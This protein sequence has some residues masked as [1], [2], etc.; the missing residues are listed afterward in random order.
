M[1][2]T[3]SSNLSSVTSLA[4][5]YSR[6][7]GQYINIA[8]G[9]GMSSMADP[10]VGYRKV[11]YEQAR[12]PPHP[13]VPTYLKASTQKPSLIQPQRQSISPHALPKPSLISPKTQTFSPI[14][15]S[16]PQNQWKGAPYS[17]PQQDFDP[18]QLKN[19]KLITP[20]E[21]I[22]QPGVSKTL[23]AGLLSA[24]LMSVPSSETF[25]KAQI[26]KEFN[27]MGPA[28]IAI[29]QEEG[30]GKIRAD[31]ISSSYSPAVQAVREKQFE[32]LKKSGIV[33][34]LAD[35]IYQKIKMKQDD[36]AMRLQIAKKMGNME[37]INQYQAEVDKYTTRIENRKSTLLAADKDPRTQAS[38]IVSISNPLVEKF[39]KEYGEGGTEI[40]KVEPVLNATE[41]YK[42]DL[43]TY[44]TELGTYNEKVRAFNLGGQGSDLQAV[45]ELNRQKA[46]LDKEQAALEIR[47][48]D[49]NIKIETIVA[50]VIKTMD[51]KKGIIDAYTA[52]YNTVLYGVA[53]PT[54][55]DIESYN[56][57]T[58]GVAIPTDAQRKTS[59]AEKELQTMV[60]NL[61]TTEQIAVN[62]FD[63]PRL[64]SAG[65]IAQ[66]EY[67]VNRATAYRADTGLGV[68]DPFVGAA[69]GLA[70]DFGAWGGPIPGALYEGYI[71][72]PVQ[73][74]YDKKI[75]SIDRKITDLSQKMNQVGAMYS[76]E[77]KPDVKPFT[78]SQI[79]QQR[80]DI[81]TEIQNLE[82]ERTTL[83]TERLG[84]FKFESFLPGI[85]EV[86]R[87]EDFGMLLTGIETAQKEREKLIEPLTKGEQEALLMQNIA[88]SAAAGGGI[89]FLAGGIGAAPGFLIGGVGGLVGG[90][91]D[92]ETQKRVKRA[93]GDLELAQK[94][95]LVTNV[96]ADIG[97]S[98][99][100]DIGIT[101][102]A[103]FLRKAPKV[104]A[105]LQNVDVVG[106][107]TFDV[108]QESFVGGTT[109]KNYNYMRVISSVKKGNKVIEQ[110]YDIVSSSTLKSSDVA[111]AIARAKASGVISPE[112]AAKAAD[113]PTRLFFSQASSTKLPSTDLAM[114]FIRV[115]G[116]SDAMIRP[117]GKLSKM[118]DSIA[119]AKSALSRPREVSGLPSISPGPRIMTLEETIAPYK[120][121]GVY[122]QDMT[123]P[124]KTKLGRLLEKVKKTKRKE[125]TIDDVFGT[126]IEGYAGRESDGFVTEYIQATTK[127]YDPMTG[128]FSDPVRTITKKTSGDTTYISQTISGKEGKVLPKITK[129]G[130]IGFDIQSDF[131]DD[132]LAVGRKVGVPEVTDAEVS[133]VRKLLQSG[134]A[135]DVD[136]SS[137][138]VKDIARNIKY[139][140]EGI[141]SQ[142]KDIYNVA[143]K[144]SKS[145]AE[146][147]YKILKSPDLRYDI[148]DIL[149]GEGA[150]PKGYFG[151]YSSVSDEIFY[152]R[153]KSLL[154]KIPDKT[155]IT[156]KERVL[157]HE[158]A[159][160]A[161]RSA[162][163]AEN[164]Y[165]K[166]LKNI[167]KSKSRTDM[168]ISDIRRQGDEIFDDLHDI[169]KRKYGEKKAEK[170]IKDK[171]S[172]ISEY[173]P[174]SVRR[175]ALAIFTENAPDEILKPTTITGKHL[176]DLYLE[177]ILKKKPGLTGL[178]LD[179]Y[180]DLIIKKGEEVVPTIQR[181][182]LLQFLGEQYSKELQIEAAERAVV[183]TQKETAIR[184]AQEAAKRDFVRQ[185]KVD[186]GKMALEKASKG[187][188]TPGLY[189]YQI[190]IKSAVGKAPS[191]QVAILTTRPGELRV[192][193]MADS[194]KIIDR[195][196]AQGRGISKADMTRIDAFFK[197]GR[198]ISKADQLVLD[199]FQKTG[200]T[201]RKEDLDRM[202]EFGKTGGRVSKDQLEMYNLF[203]KYS[204]TNEGRMMFEDILKKKKILESEIY[205]FDYAPSIGIGQIPS[206]EA[207]GL[208]RP[209][210]ESM[211]KTETGISFPKKD[212]LSSKKSLLSLDQLT[213][214]K[215]RTDTYLPAKNIQDY[216]TM[217]KPKQI[218]LSKAKTRELVRQDADT[219]ART[220]A[221]VLEGT[222]LRTEAL[223]DIKLR[224]D[225]A[226]KTDVPIIPGVPFPGIP[227]IPL[228][229]FLPPG[230]L[231]GGKTGTGGGV[232]GFPGEK[233]RG[234]R[235]LI[236][237]KS[238]LFRKF[239]FGEKDF[240]VDAES[241][242]RFKR[243]IG[244]KGTF[245]GYDAIPTQEQL[246]RA[247]N[248][249]WKSQA[250]A[251]Y[252][253]GQKSILD[254]SI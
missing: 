124:P 11:S 5:L 65:D 73:D 242:S 205:R 137:M 131:M 75:T 18:R 230:S 105:T 31:V 231:A 78:Q 77:Y 15:D 169:F 127:K 132:A 110:A 85:A 248:K 158:L 112:T 86:Q 139:N 40:I 244:K 7:G 141:I 160:K 20:E 184:A 42:E 130:K 161:D 41:T 88:I 206:P 163:A 61:N 157:I 45:I 193:A 38:A 142:Y 121:V 165:I 100:L 185:V 27:I 8:T 227:L 217:Y 254:I 199:K 186:V 44:E 253:K 219:R 47:K 197:Q 176:Q 33:D 207:F 89:G 214:I 10:G 115:S 235:P 252:L 133:A 25:A 48:T 250:E 53:E 71:N 249:L 98:S 79:N 191:S 190:A 216:M 59:A 74:V 228:F 111:E 118:S 108:V 208:V 26:E 114:N 128:E 30:K 211:T 107:K 125:Y 24:D 147:F 92:I 87:P 156:S 120:K 106:S 28:T 246:N 97:V 236:Q 210:Q 177:K 192:D 201:I 68:L 226:L 64:K 37:N 94:S 116:E 119:M 171:A 164:E 60:E 221:D 49:L 241:F 19:L 144:T 82:K 155:G 52:N 238:S 175:E 134:F 129:E 93:T 2:I 222:R 62:V 151:A 56:V 154:D 194:Q 70:F 232:R 14:T 200:G 50:P 16:I 29:M 203:K 153:S 138:S 179:K 239:A 243:I 96:L 212:F 145:D 32:V 123:T 36:A 183:Q 136:L 13:V 43:V 170:L 148:V 57:R 9:Q 104:E 166:F 152:S 84:E 237:V 76:F 167:K 215:L 117:V 22:T 58:Y 102:G 4:S 55:A 80:K 196:T 240:E 198:G 168:F 234:R 189:G 247:E 173:S 202:L 21:K 126:N 67:I 135:D 220:R 81:Q 1:A 51:E 233:A 66:S 150:A 195:F 204:G 162:I 180:A 213:D 140:K 63:D 224:T 3:P 159:H 113:D 229:G 90:L 101:G 17:Y 181:K 245:F 188:F 54:K 69:S 178:E 72:P 187:D 146:A 149:T 223:E 251:K 46:I 218:E 143:R 225:T 39:N 174:T 6:G 83:L 103:T 99:A 95:G 172:V 109:T 34:I 209:I 182:P 12:L 35:P 23:L 122:V 91:A